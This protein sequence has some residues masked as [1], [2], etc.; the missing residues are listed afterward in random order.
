MVTWTDSV[1]RTAAGWVSFGVVIGNDGFNY[2]LIVISVTW[3]IF[4]Y[5]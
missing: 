5:T 2:K 3:I 1:V 4:G